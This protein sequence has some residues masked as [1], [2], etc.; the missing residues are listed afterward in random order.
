M[1]LFTCMKH[2][3]AIVEHR[4]LSKAA[5]HIYVPPAV[6]SKHLSWLEEHLGK[7]LIKRTTRR[8][9]LT[10]EGQVYYSACKELLNKLAETEKIVK[11]N[12]SEPS[13]NIVLA[14]TSLIARAGL[15][16]HLQD[17]LSLHSQIKVT[18]INQSSPAIILENLGDLLITSIEYHDNQLISHHLFSSPRGVY[19]APAYLKKFGTPKTVDDLITHNCLVSSTSP[20]GEYWEF[21]AKKKVA[22][23]GNF[24][25][26]AGMDIMLAADLGLGLMW[27]AEECLKEELAQGKLEEVK[28]KEN[29]LNIDIFLYYRPVLAN[30]II[31]LLADYLIR[32]FKAFN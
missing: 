10:Q 27:T 17:F 16:S 9:E 8:F 26:S 13:G 2:Y 4:G 3:A 7:K 12:K 14:S 15:F 1:D 32:N 31:K 30:N 11:T 25:A 18:F 29:N 6:L 24:V 22:V 23:K 20:Q 28:L 19:A 21:A 5:S